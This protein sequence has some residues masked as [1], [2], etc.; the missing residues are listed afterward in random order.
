MRAFSSATLKAITRSTAWIRRNGGRL[1]ATVVIIIATAWATAY[2]HESE[3]SE[4]SRAVAARWHA[5]LAVELQRVRDVL[6]QH[7]KLLEAALP[8]LKAQLHDLNSGGTPAI[9][10]LSL[11]YSS[12]SLAVWQQLQFRPLVN[13][14]P[15]EWYL[16]VAELHQRLQIYA[17]VKKDIRADFRTLAMVTGAGLQRRSDRVSVTHDLFGHV[18]L[19]LAL[20][21]GLDSAMLKVI[22]QTKK[23]PL[24]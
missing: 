10:Q 1:A 19:A 11:P 15:V 14:L 5:A 9:V 8:K 13:Y 22:E 6:P 12:M 17:E 18:E 20:I 3:R 4:T 2:F 23:H 21:P 16:D 7:K 24:Y